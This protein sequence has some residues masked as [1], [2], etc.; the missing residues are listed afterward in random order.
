MFVTEKQTKEGASTATLS[1]QQNKERRNL[2][3]HKKPRI[4]IYFFFS[5]EIYYTSSIPVCY[6][7]KTIKHKNFILSFKYGIRKSYNLTKRNII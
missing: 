1:E 2:K 7:V 5:S 6:T 3:K 4:I